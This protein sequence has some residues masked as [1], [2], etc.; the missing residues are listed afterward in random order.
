MPDVISSLDE[1]TPERMTRILKRIDDSIVVDSAPIKLSKELAYSTVAR[2]E[3]EYGSQ[4]RGPVPS[5][6]FLKLIRHDKLE[7]IVG[8]PDAEIEFYE[9]VA[10]L[11]P[12]PPIVRCFDAA[13]SQDQGR[14]H[15]LLADLCDTH[16]HPPQNTAPGEHD[17]LRAVEA[18]A[19][20]HAR[21]WHDA[22]LENDIGKLM[23]GA[24]LA[25]FIYNLQTDVSHF[26][27][28]F[29]SYLTEDHRSAYQLMVSNAP[30]IWGRLADRT[31]LTLTHG[32]CHWWN[33]LF[34]RDAAGAVY[35]IDW[36]LWHIDL[37]ARDLAFL[38]ALGGFAE[39]RPEIERVL[40]K[41]YHGTLV[42][43]GVKDHSFDQ[44]LVDYRW[45]AIRNL[46]IPVIF[47][48]QRKHET[49]VQTALRRAYD[50]FERLDCREL[51]A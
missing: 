27:D 35:I 18:L 38:L 47:W 44:L 32:D 39:P 41:R 40:L 51:I 20:C 45:S 7:P 37:G 13:T 1:I 29:E 17:S 10:P 34:P 3:L 14:A 6:V 24:A 8:M 28:A 9:R 21:W 49:T 12:S 26:V 2:L 11:M 33:F 50:S 30:K 46:N 48:S 23:N 15:L 4:Y 42:A 43:N 16:S 22:R 25:T 19:Q 36:H 5:N 31:G